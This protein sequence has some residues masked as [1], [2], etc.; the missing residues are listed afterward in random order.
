MLHLCLNCSEDY[1]V[2]KIFKILNRYDFLDPCFVCSQLCGLTLPYDNLNDVRLRLGEV[3][4]NLTRYGDREDA[5]YVAQATQ[6]A[7]VCTSI[8]VIVILFQSWGRICVN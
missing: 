7:Q 8:V 5:N 4:P 1:H 6:L 3:A 2:E